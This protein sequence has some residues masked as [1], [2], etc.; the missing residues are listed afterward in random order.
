MHQREAIWSK[1]NPDGHWRSFEYQ[2]LLRRDKLSFDLFWLRDE[3]LEV[4]DI[5]PEPDILAA[6][7]AVDLQDALEQFA[8]V[9]SDLLAFASRMATT[10]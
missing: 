8:S 9:A 7:M 5:L 6:E 10:E 4:N 1:D 3:R 2:R